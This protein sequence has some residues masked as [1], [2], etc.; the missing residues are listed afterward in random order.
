VL[1]SVYLQNYHSFSPVEI[2]E[3]MKSGGVEPNQVGIQ[4]FCFRAIGSNLYYTHKMHK[5]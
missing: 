1:L 3:E 5:L 4:I 2:L